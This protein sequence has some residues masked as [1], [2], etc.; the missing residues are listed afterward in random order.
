MAIR[1]SDFRLGAIERLGECSITREHGAY[2]V[3]RAG[4]GL[5]YSTRNLRD[6]RRAARV[7]MDPD[8]Y[9]S[10]SAL[11]RDYSRHLDQRINELKARE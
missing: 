2:V 8:V 7:G 5:V 11:A 3:R 4:C 1:A 6:A 9:A 10:Q